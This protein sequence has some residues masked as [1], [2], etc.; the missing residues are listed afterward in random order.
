MRKAIFLFSILALLMGAL[1]V[2]AQ[3]DTPVDPATFEGN[4]CNEGGK[5]YDPVE[6]A[7]FTNR[8][9]AQPDAWSVA[10][11]W[12][13]GWYGALYDAGGITFEALFELDPTI[14]GNIITVD[15]P[16]LLIEP[17]PPVAVSGIV[18]YS[19][20]KAGVSWYV[21]GE[22]FRSLDCSDFVNKFMVVTAPDTC[23]LGWSSYQPIS[24]PEWPSDKALCEEP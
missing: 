1:V 5:W 10:F 3:D 2:S 15:H 18:C 12:V 21:T 9:D 13:N 8:C 16:N 23:P 14:A 6:Y 20:E 22:L 7:P 4:W 11:M 17:E 19:E 24:V